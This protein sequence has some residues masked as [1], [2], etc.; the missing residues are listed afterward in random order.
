MSIEWPIDEDF[1]LVSVPF[2]G[3]RG[4]QVHQVDVSRDCRCRVSVPF[5]GFRGLQA[6]ATSRYGE[7]IRG[8]SP[9]PGF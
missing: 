1:E 4:L 9:L 7:P 3:F 2:R 8:F 6:R 5:R